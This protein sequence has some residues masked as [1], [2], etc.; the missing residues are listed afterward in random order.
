MKLITF[1]FAVVLSL[2]SAAR[3]QEY[4]NSQKLPDSP[5]AHKF[6]TLES[7]VNFSIFWG[8]LGADAITTEI[9]LGLG[10]REMNPLARPLVS[11]GAGGQSVASGLSLGAALGLTYLLHRT[12]HHTAETDRRPSADRGGRRRRAPQYCGV[13]PRS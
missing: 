10:V 11:Q 8:E 13:R 9:G 7:K 5:G 3:A 1:C 12:Q 2:Q 6:W 4:V